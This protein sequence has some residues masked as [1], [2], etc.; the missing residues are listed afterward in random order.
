MSIFTG[1]AEQEAV[2]IERSEH[3]HEQI[4]PDNWSCAPVKRETDDKRKVA[5]ALARSD[6]HEETVLGRIEAMLSSVLGNI[7]RGAVPTLSAF[8]K[9]SAEAA[10]WQL[11]LFLGSEEDTQRFC[12]AI[13]VLE[14]IHVSPRAPTFAFLG[15]LL[16]PFN[17]LPIVSDLQN[18]LFL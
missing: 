10:S 14:S 8:G 4:F 9:G 11:R 2:Q 17:I 5:Q 12:R 1:L 3:T 15:S 6:C 13:A 7:N 18:T 16:T